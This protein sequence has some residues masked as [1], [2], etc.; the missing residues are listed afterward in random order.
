MSK[1]KYLF[2][3]SRKI[4]TVV[5][6][7]LE[8]FCNA[9][10][11][12]LWTAYWIE[13]LKGVMKSVSP[14]SFAIAKGQRSKREL[15]IYVINSD[16]NTNLSWIELSLKKR[17]IVEDLRFGNLGISLGLYSRISPSF[18]RGIFSHLLRLDQ[19]R[20]GKNSWWILNSDTYP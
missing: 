9:R 17:F 2:I 15:S 13:W 10:E 3:F 16:G 1:D 7:I 20:S 6:F 19:S 4:E 8:I 12:Y 18:S 11:K 5:F 14:S